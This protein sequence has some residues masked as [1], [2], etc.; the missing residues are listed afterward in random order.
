MPLAQAAEEARAAAGEM[1][2][3]SSSAGRGQR[4]GAQR[5]GQRASQ[6]MGRVQQQVREQREG[7]QQEWRQE[8][9]AELDRALLE[10][11]RLA[12]RQL[13]VAE[14]F[15]RPSAT[16]AARTAQGTVEEGV[17][18]LLEQGG[19]ATGKNTPAPPRLSAR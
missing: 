5:A 18:K 2:E 6:H 15:R 13:D 8:V 17:Q 9:V 1:R 19:S 14:Q 10:T 4:Q 11:T 16:A 12:E 3:G 7:Q